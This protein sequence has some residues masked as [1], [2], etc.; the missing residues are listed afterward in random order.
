MNIFKIPSIEISD[1][2]AVEN[3][4]HF[5]HE[6]LFYAIDAY[7]KNKNIKWVVHNNLT[8]WENKFTLMCIK[9]LNI[10]YEI[11]DLTT[12]YKN[13]YNYN[14]NNNWDRGSP[15]IKNCCPENYDNIMS[16]IQNII[17]L[18]FPD[19]VYNGN[20][21][22]LY[23]RNDAGRR[24]M[25]NYNGNLDQY[26]DE[27]VYDFENMSFEDQVKVF[28]KCSHFV[29]IEGTNLTANIIFMNKK[30]K[31][32]G[33]SSSNNSWP[34]VFGT[35]KLI[36]KFIQ[37]CLEKPMNCVNDDILYTSELEDRIKEFLEV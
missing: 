10:Y 30:A 23:F 17:K 25:I 1:H 15:D 28:M 8:E 34:L 6:I 2:G 26:F 35:S 9:H 20:Y 18:E 37:Y 32:F 7:L 12:E 4:G 11:V 16:M 5:F 33:L 13:I 14:N 24:K 22:V 31:V 29:T 27:I 3:I 21:K 36:D 19:T